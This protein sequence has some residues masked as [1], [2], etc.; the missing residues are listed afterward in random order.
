MSVAVTLAVG[1]N[2]DGRHE[3]L[4]MAIGA[5]EAEP[6]WTK[7]LRDLMR[8]G[9]CGVKLV[10]SDAH[11]GI[12]ATFLRLTADKEMID[13]YRSLQHVLASNHQT[14]GMSHPPDRRLADTQSLSQSNRR[15]AFVRL[16]NEPHAF[17]PHT[18]GKLGGVL[19]RVPCRSE[20]DAAI[21]VGTLI[22]TWTSP[23]LSH[24]TGG[25]LKG[26]FIATRR[27][28]PSIRP[29]HRFHQTPTT[30]FVMSS[31]VRITESTASTSSDIEI[32][33]KTC[34]KNLI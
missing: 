27:A 3:V 19:R 16:Q 18:Q 33:F 29:N 32:S 11:E 7:F 23:A 5:S 4:G 20:L 2:T 24:V 10:I 9:L 31:T 34:L 21:A 17:Q 14:Q 13:L 12:T 6:F 22:K 30:R 1:V 8:R 28:D 25:N 15:H 26:A